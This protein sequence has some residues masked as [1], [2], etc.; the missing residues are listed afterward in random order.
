MD[1]RPGSCVGAVGGAVS[2]GCVLQ[3]AYTSPSLHIPQMHPPYASL[4]RHLRAGPARV[5]PPCCCAPQGQGVVFT[6]VARRLEGRSSVMVVPPPNS[7]PPAAKN[8]ATATME[9]LL[10]NDDISWQPNSSTPS[11]ISVT[12]TTAS[13]GC[14][15]CVRA[16]MRVSCVCGCVVCMRTCLRARAHALVRVRVRV[17]ARARARALVLVRVRVRACVL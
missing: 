15:W 6:V 2:R 3:A 5:Y 4:Y 10:N 8:K 9:R 12:C 11:W 14:S 16:C 7:R 13:S 17:R 1:R